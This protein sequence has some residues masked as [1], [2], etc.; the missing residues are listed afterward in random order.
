MLFA[1]SPQQAAIAGYAQWCFDALVFVCL[2][3]LLCLP[4]F[5]Q[6][7]KV[8]TKD[9]LVYVWIPA[10]TYTSGCSP[11][12]R[13]C[14]EW[15]KPPTRV[16]IHG[17]WIGRTEVTQQAYEEVMGTNPSLYR[18]PHRPV[19]RVSWNEALRYCAAMGMRLPTEVEWEY[20]ARGGTS[21]ARYGSLAGCGKVA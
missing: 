4:A 14:F 12:D 21:S 13:E 9:H 1:S 16:F 18:G 2:T 19:E 11:S 5:S 17:F 7:V 3:G 10:G 6:R 8:N 15:E 20:A